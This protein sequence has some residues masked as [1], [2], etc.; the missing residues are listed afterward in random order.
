[1]KVIFRSVDGS[2]CHQ[3]F[4]HFLKFLQ[5]LNE[6]V[7]VPSLCV[8]QLSRW[9]PLREPHK[10]IIKKTQRCNFWEPILWILYTFS[11][12]PGK[13]SRGCIPDK[14]F[15]VPVLMAPREN[16]AQNY[17]NNIIVFNISLEMFSAFRFSFLGQKEVAVTQTASHQTWNSENDVDNLRQL[18]FSGT[19]RPIFLR[20]QRETKVRVSI[21]SNPVI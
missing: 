4:S 8:P 20:F 19:M 1:M 3:N 13:G 16:T 6:F 17:L 15:S 5:R 18:S 9:G 12:V 10:V 7:P 2:L 14:P 11:T 21:T